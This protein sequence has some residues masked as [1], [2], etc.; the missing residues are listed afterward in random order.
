MELDHV[1]PHNLCG[2]TRRDVT[3]T[4]KDAMIIGK[5]EVLLLP[6]FKMADFGNIKY[7]SK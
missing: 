5:R 1:L 3:D 4:R 2:N 7:M 6:K